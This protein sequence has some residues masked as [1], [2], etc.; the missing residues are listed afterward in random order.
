MTCTSTLA[1]SEWSILAPAAFTPK[2][3][4]LLKKQ[5]F[6][7]EEENPSGVAGNQLESSAPT[8]CVKP[9]PLITSDCAQ[10]RP[11]TGNIPLPFAP[12]IMVIWRS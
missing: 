10:K 8:D 2:K 5:S 6:S 12:C 3:I 1:G 11:I 9:Q 4:L 7:S